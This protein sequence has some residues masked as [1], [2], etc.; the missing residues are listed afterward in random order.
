M[1]KTPNGG[2][3]RHVSQLERCLTE[4]PFGVFRIVDGHVSHCEKACFIAWNVKYGMPNEAFCLQVSERQ[5]FKNMRQEWRISAKYFRRG[6]EMC[7]FG[8]SLLA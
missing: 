2:S 7:R 6:K 3:V 1:R 4:P 5:A 8:Y